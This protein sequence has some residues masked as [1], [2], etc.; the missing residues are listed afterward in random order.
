MHVH[1]AGTG[2][3]GSGCWMRLKGLHR[4]LAGLMLRGL[5]LP[6]NALD[7]DFDRLYVERL[8]ALIRS[9]SLGAVVLLAHDQVYE[10]GGR[11]MEGVGSFYVPNQKCPA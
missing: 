7:E 6:G 3:S 4:V 8:L 2:S 9:S 1:L 10:A 11:L 5:G